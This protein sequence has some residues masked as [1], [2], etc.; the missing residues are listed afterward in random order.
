M[1]WGAMLWRPRSC[2]GMTHQFPCCARGRGTTKQGRLWTY[3]R[4]DRAAAS[5]DAPAVLFRYS[6]D[7]K[8][9]RPQAH[10]ATFAG[11][12]T[13]DGYAG[14]DRLGISQHRC[15]RFGLPLD[16]HCQCGAERVQSGRYGASASDAIGVSSSRSAPI[17]TR[18]AVSR[19]PTF[20]ALAQ[21]AEQQYPVATIAASQ[22]EL[23]RERQGSLAAGEA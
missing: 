9:E 8:G 19:F 13:A 16:R 11:V 2:M 7:R 10:L 14:F 20:P 23:R 4:D 21:M 22:A 3:V 12:L 5:T 18:S 6:A 17:R 1:P 15:L